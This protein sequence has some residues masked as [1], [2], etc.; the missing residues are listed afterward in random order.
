MSYTLSPCLIDL[1][2]LCE[3]VGSRDESLITAVLGPEPNELKDA[4]ETDEDA[5]V[6][7]A[8]TPDTPLRHLVMGQPL[9]EEAGSEYGYAL[10]RLC[11][12]LGEMIP[13]DLWCG[14]R[15]M[16]ITDGGLEDLL[17]KTGSPVPIPERDFPAIGHWTAKE[18][19]DKVAQLGDSHLTCD[20]DDLQELLDEY[21][22]WLRAAAAKGKAIVF[23]YY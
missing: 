4:W 15:W 17:T 8:F 10:M 13:P 14:V 18:V 3:A 1:E 12:H 7:G 5:E 9:I 21:E 6:E 16:A 22:G 20:S 19:A 11:E 23:F 2:K